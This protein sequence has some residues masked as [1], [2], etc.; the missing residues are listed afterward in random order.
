MFLD[1]VIHL[2]KNLGDQVKDRSPKK[3]E[4]FMEIPNE[5]HLK[6]QILSNNMILISSP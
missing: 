2:G 4:L 6:V 5:A 1:Q 3:L